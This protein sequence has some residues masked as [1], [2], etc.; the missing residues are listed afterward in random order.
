MDIPDV[1]LFLKVGYVLL[2][3]T[4]IPLSFTETR[5][6]SWLLLIT[7]LFCAVSRFSIAVVATYFMIK[8]GNSKEETLYYTK[9]SVLYYWVVLLTSLIMLHMR[10]ELKTVFEMMQ[11]VEEMVTRNWTCQNKVVLLWRT[12]ILLLTTTGAALSAISNTTNILHIIQADMNKTEFTVVILYAYPAYSFFWAVCYNTVSIWTTELQ[13][14]R[15]IIDRISSDQYLSSL[16]SIL[17]SA[18]AN[19]SSVYCLNDLT[20]SLS[21]ESSTKSTEHWSCNDKMLK[22]LTAKK[23]FSEYTNRKLSTSVTMLIVIDSFFMPLVFSAYYQ[24]DFLMPANFYYSAYLQVSWILCIF[25]LPFFL[26]EW[27]KMVST[28]CV[29][30]AKKNIY[31]VSDPRSKRMMYKFIQSAGDPYPDCHW[32]L[33]CIDFELISELFNVTILLSTTFILP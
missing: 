31:M 13:L 27:N 3:L 24:K 28:N 18:N 14:N 9:S 6:S 11:N 26:K 10:K 15:N 22:M 12:F 30:E 29:Q 5:I 7:S 21:F 33:F 32:K 25:I 20:N 1:S 23:M 2:V 16:R 19:L 17:P 4:G 8:T